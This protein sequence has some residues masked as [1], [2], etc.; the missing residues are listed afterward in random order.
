M[1]C[2]FLLPSR[3]TGTP[4]C[5]ERQCGKVWVVL[6]SQGQGQAQQPLSGRSHHRWSGICALVI[7]AGSS[8]LA[9]GSDLDLE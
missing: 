2:L 4:S 5:S 1:L 7:L 3:S 9:E 8:D 6:V